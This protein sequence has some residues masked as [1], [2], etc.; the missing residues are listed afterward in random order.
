MQRGIAADGAA[1]AV[2][3]EHVVC[4]GTGFGCEGVHRFV[5]CKGICEANRS[6]RSHA[7]RSS[8]AG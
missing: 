2:K 5:S 8:T 6:A 7:A 4:G 1:S 3:A